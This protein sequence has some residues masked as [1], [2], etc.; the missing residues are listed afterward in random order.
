MFAVIMAGGSGT[1]FW[2]RSREAIPK[3]FLP[4]ASKRT[5]IEETVARLLPLVSYENIFFVIGEDHLNILRKEI[6]QAPEENILIEPAG[7]ST[8]PC[9]AFAAAHLQRID[10][11]DV[12][13]ALPAD[14]HI[15]DDTVFR[16]SLSAAVERARI[17]EN[18]IT[19]GVKPTY[20][21]TGYG[22]IEIGKKEAEI[23]GCEI[24]EVKRFVEKPDRKKAETYLR[25]GNF[26]WNS[27]IFVFGIKTILSAF[28]EYQPGLYPLIKD[29]ADA[30]TEDEEQKAV[31]ELYKRAP[32]DSIDYAIMEKAENILC[33][34][35][36]F[37]WS[38]LGSFKALKAVWRKDKKGNRVR[39]ELIGI[40]AFENIV[41]SLEKPVAAIGVSNLVIVETD[42]VLLVCHEDR[43]QEVKKIIERLKKEGRNELL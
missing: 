40:D 9:I 15:G 25:G 14:H 35:G 30:K 41:D 2:P 10:P 36:V 27:G 33:V 3:Q 38:D 28:A 8:A 31:A 6:P 13:V 26:L 34:K 4:I 19:F 39:G 29:I 22:Y 24:F 11:D 23:E 20:P 12:M 16:R 37:P 21:E 17:K 1:R 43:A 18:I 32:V 7:K 5:M 42:D